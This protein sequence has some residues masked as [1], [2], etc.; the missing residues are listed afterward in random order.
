MIFKKEKSRTKNEDKRRTKGAA[1]I[2]KCFNVFG[3]M[4]RAELSKAE[5]KEIVFNFPCV[6]AATQV[7]FATTAFQYIL[8]NLILF[9]SFE[10]E[11]NEKMATWIG[12]YLKKTT[13]RQNEIMTHFVPSAK[14]PTK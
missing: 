9:L 11:K 12:P 4:F 8:L 5:W 2:S 13:M 1:A 14:D 10:C 7:A 3:N 6:D